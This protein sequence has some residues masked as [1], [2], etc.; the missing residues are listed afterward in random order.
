[1]SGLHHGSPDS[2]DGIIDL[3]EFIRLLEHPQLQALCVKQK[4]TKLAAES[5]KELG[6]Y[7]KNQLYWNLIRIKP[8]LL[9]F[10]LDQWRFSWEWMG[11]NWKKW[12]C[13][14]DL[15]VK[16]VEISLGFNGAQLDQQWWWSVLCGDLRWGFCAIDGNTLGICCWYPW[17]NIYGM[18]M[19]I[20]IVY[21]VQIYYNV[22]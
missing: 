3:P 20:Y 21:S 19:Y 8:T 6:F 2:G 18:C 14:L 22:L 1:M 9:G 13:E 17:G 4:P 16:N 5:N 12:G 10:S 7:W 11:V 15:T